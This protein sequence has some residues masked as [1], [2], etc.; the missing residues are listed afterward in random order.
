[1]ARATKGPAGSK[2]KT[3]ASSGAAKT[4][5]RKTAANSKAATIP[6]RKTGTRTRSPDRVDGATPT[7]AAPPS[8]FRAPE[9][10]ISRTSPSKSRATGWS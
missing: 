5:K 2:H 8:P 7:G 1:M 4:P 3:A 10:T 6:K 9:S